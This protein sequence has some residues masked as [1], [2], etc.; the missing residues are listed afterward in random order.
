MPKI[1]R[2]AGLRVFVK[3]KN[4]ARRPTF[5][6]ISQAQGLYSVNSSNRK[7]CCAGVTTRV[8]RPRP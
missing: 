2:G 6:V 7:I 4:A 5:M 3:M 8:S 1:D